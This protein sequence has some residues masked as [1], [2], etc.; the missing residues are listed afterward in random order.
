[1][2]RV[3][4]KQVAATV[5]VSPSTVSNVVNN[6][7]EHVSPG[8][9]RRVR[10]AITEIGYIPDVVGRNLRRRSTESIGVIILNM[11]AGQL[12]EPWF[13]TLISGIS[14]VMSRYDKSMLVDLWQPGA[15][16]R[17]QRAFHGNLF[18]GAILIGPKKEERILAALAKERYPFVALEWSEPGTSVDSVCSN[19]LHG[20]YLAVKHLI[21]LGH[22]RIAMLNGDT[23]FY[24]ARERLNGY[25]KALAE[26]DLPSDPA[27]IVT[28][29]FSEAE[30]FRR[31]AELMGLPDPPTAFFTGDDLLALGVIGC[32][33]Q[34]G[35]A[36]PND[37]S[38]VGFDDIPLVKH[39]T[40]PLTTVR[41]PMWEMGVAAAERLQ[42][43]LTADRP[44][45]RQIL[46]DVE[47]I[48]RESTRAK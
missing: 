38:V 21:E 42:Q 4:I 14:S 48:V 27:L 28:G 22:R 20:G 33:R 25:L 19:D 13:A 29:E 10:K 2:G 15:E 30:G 12:S 5:G 40:P 6:R 26:H 1:M 43:I 8:T 32:L 46:F 3:T 47:L 36:V 18:D 23:G 24:S 16:R 41:L 45:P 34:L 39:L 7:L 44:Q 37:V 9:V 35:L 11:T 17:H 31:T